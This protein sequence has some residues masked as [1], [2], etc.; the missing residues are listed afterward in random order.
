MAAIGGMKVAQEA[1]AA[2]MEGKYPGKIVIFPQI[3][4]LPLLGL[5]ELAEKLPDIADKLG[6]D[7]VW[8][9]EAEAALIEKYW[10]P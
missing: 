3:H 2:V 8:T 9:E 1:M 4:D 7:H 10:R 6:S 5:D